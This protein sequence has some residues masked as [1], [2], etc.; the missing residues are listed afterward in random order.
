[1]GPI[2]TAIEQIRRDDLAKLT[3]YTRHSYQI[4]A[5]E[6]ERWKHEKTWQF[7]NGER[8]TLDASFCDFNLVPA[9]AGYELLWF[10]GWKCDDPSAYDIP[11]H[12]SRTPVIGWELYEGLVY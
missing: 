10:E 7:A 12:V 4:E 9:T 3:E 1:M 8:V 11:K 5:A 2:E 6:D